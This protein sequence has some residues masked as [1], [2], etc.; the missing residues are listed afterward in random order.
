[1]NEM[2]TTMKENLDAQSYAMTQ[3]QDYIEKL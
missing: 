3:W 2:F 1:M